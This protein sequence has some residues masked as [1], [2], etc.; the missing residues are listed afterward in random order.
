LSE[1]MLVKQATYEYISPCLLIIE[2]GWV[3]KLIH[4]HIY[5]KLVSLQ[6]Q[7]FTNLQIHM[8][9]LYGMQWHPTSVVTFPWFKTLSLRSSKNFNQ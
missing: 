1:Q 4:T 3:I 7:I 6:L 8:F 9:N 5:M 2:C